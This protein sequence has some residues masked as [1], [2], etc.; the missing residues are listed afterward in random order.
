MCRTRETSIHSRIH[1][2]EVELDAWMSGRD[3]L[4]PAFGAM[5]FATPSI[6]ACGTLSLSPCSGRISH[7]LEILT[8]PYCTIS[9]CRQR[10]ELGIR[11]S[12]FHGTVFHRLRCAIDI[13]FSIFCLNEKGDICGFSAEKEGCQEAPSTKLNNIRA[14]PLCRCG[15]DRVASCVTST[16]GGFL[17]F[18]AHER[19][20]LDENLMHLDNCSYV[21][22]KSASHS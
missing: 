2:D 7:D 6:V 17:F 1:A 8:G 4:L 18:P 15:R 20:I 12:G 16:P 21:E 5:S 13:P 14:V 22:L 19:F 11:G 10:L 9:C 3:K